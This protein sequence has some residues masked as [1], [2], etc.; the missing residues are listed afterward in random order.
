M[1]I[2]FETWG[3]SSAASGTTVGRHGTTAQSGTTV[4]GHGT[5]AVS[6]GVKTE[7]VRGRSPHTP[8]QFPLLSSRSSR[9][10]SWHPP[11]RAASV[12]SFEVSS[13]GI[14]P[15]PPECH[16][17]RYCPLFSVL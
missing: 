9:F 6:R 16:G 10:P 14:D 11:R 7:G 2:L 13:G 5:T 3:I 17:S 1:P 8:I 15:H 12:P 4:G